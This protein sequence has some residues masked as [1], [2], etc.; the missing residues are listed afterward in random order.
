MTQRLMPY[1]IFTTSL[2]VAILVFPNFYLSGTVA[3]IFSTFLILKKLHKVSVL[4]LALISTTVTF[5]FPLALL[6]FI[7]NGSGIS[8]FQ[9]KY[10]TLQ[11]ILSLIA[12][13]IIMVIAV[14]SIR[15]IFLEK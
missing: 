13:T 12:P 3:A 15:R 2:A 6:F 7:G 11:N 14:I 9:E 1:L 8:P 4:V 5:V 10:L